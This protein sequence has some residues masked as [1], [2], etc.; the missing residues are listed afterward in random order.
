MNI[1]GEILLILQTHSTIPAPFGWFHSISWII[2]ILAGIWLC[3]K[4]KN[5][6]EK[7]VRRILLTMGLICIIL[8]I[9]K[10]IV[11][12]FTYEG[13]IFTHD[14][15]WYAFPYQFCSTP[16]YVQLL[17][18][19]IKKKPIHRSL[20]AFL[21]TYAIF[22]GICVMVY[23]NDVFTRL[24][25]VN[26]QTMICHGSMLSIGIFLYGSGYVKTE[27]KTLY[28]AI[29]VFV[30]AT[31]LAVVMN[32]WVVAS[33][34]LGDD[35]FNMFYIS[36][37]FGTTLP[38]YSTVLKYVPYPWSLILYILIFTIAALLVLAFAT[39]LKKLV[40]TIKKR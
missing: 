36:R 7:T 9:Y 6:N 35:V 26:V 21:A 5:P 32:E 37:H 33:G 8:E 16:M 30:L 14:Y 2:S 3:I 34:V 13:G 11:F 29:P 18:G 31:A 4:F 40:S 19:I 27:M 38:V 25:G 20:C 15:Q 39:L 28:R 12:T 23:P 1:L 24:V 22:A 17:T 10:Q